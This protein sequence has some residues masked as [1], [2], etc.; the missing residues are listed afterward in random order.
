LPR[1]SADSTRWCPGSR[2]T[3]WFIAT[4]DKVMSARHTRDTFRL[5]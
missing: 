1:H 3:A 5:A 4:D 2:V